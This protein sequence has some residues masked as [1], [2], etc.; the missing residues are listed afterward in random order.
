MPS[1]RERE[2]KPGIAQARTDGPI[3]PICDDLFLFRLRQHFLAGCRELVAGFGKAGDD[4]SA[5]GY[6]PLQYFS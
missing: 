6:L 5:A 3:T 4:P 1:Y 2:P